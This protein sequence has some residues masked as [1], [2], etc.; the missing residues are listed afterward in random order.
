M[1]EINTITDMLLSLSLFIKTFPLEKNFNHS[2]AQG[3]VDDWHRSVFRYI[4]HLWT[5]IEHSLF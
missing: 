4:A 1:S 3:T 5:E 2:Q